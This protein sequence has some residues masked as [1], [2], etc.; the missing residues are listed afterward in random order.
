MTSAA[1]APAIVSLK[2]FNWESGQEDRTWEDVKIA[3]SSS[4]NDAFDEVDGE[5]GSCHAGLES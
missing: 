1:A 3:E 4:E 5:A 2:M